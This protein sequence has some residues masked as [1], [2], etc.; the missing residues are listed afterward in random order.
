MPTNAETPEAPAGKKAAKKQK[1]DSPVLREDR[2][3]QCRYWAEDLTSGIE[4][5]SGDC[6]LVPPTVLADG[7][8]AIFCVLPFTG[9]EDWCGLFSQRVQ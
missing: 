2:C 8:G 4:G 3:E 1:A 5:R 7:E 9:P 6:R